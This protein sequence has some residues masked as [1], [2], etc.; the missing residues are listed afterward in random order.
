MI[1]LFSKCGWGLTDLLLQVLHIIRVGRFPPDPAHPVRVQLA[2]KARRVRCWC[3]IIPK[4]PG[5]AHGF[6]RVRLDHLGIAL[7]ADGKV[8]YA[9]HRV[10][11]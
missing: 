8:E 1:R 7:L 5:H 2:R 11:L 6:I 3:R 10:A 9:L 4:L